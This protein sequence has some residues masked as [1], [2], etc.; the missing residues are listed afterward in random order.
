MTMIKKTKTITAMIL[1]AVTSSFDIPKLN[2]AGA[3]VV[4]GHAGATK[5]VVKLQQ[6]IDDHEHMDL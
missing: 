5:D 2:D 6:Q 4:A 1:G 3:G